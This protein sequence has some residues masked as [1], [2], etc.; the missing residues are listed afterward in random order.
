MSWALS[1][2]RQENEVLGLLPLDP[3][4][5]LLAK[6]ELEL[7][8]LGGEDV[9]RR[10]ADHVGHPQ[11]LQRA[12]R[13]R[14]E[15]EVGDLLGPG[16]VH[17]VVGPTGVP[18]EGVGPALPA[19]LVERRGV[20][21][22]LLA[23]GF[24][25]PEHRLPRPAEQ[26]VRP[27]L[28]EEAGLPALADARVPEVALE[29]LGPALH[30][31][32][33]LDGPEVLSISPVEVLVQV[34]ERDEHQEV[35]VTVV[36]DA[37]AVAHRRHVHPVVGRGGRTG[38]Q[39]QSECGGRGAW[40]P[41]MLAR[42]PDA[43]RG[44][45]LCRCMRTP[46]IDG[47]ETL[48]DGE[49]AA[50]RDRF[51]RRGLRPRGAGPRRVGGPGPAGHGVAAPGALDAAR[52]GRRRRP[53]GAA[54]LL[55]RHASRPP[56]SR[57]SLGEGLV[58]RL[59]E[60]GLLQERAA[61]LACPFRLIPLEGL[62]ILGDEPSAGADAVM[63]P[64]PTTLELLRN[65]PAR[66]DGAVL[67]LGTGA[68]TFALALAGR[69]ASRVVATD[70]NPRAASI[71]RFNARLNGLAARRPRRATSRP[72]CA[73]SAFAGSSPSRRTSSGRPRLRRWSSSTEARGGTS[74]PFVSWR[75]SP[76]CWRIRGTAL[77]LFDTPLEPSSPLPARVRGALADDGLELL[78]LAAPGASAGAQAVAYAALAHPDLGPDYARAVERN[79]AH[80]EA[81]GS[82]EW[83]HVL[84][85]VRRSPGGAPFTVQLPVTGLLT[86]GPAALEALLSGID[87][88][89]LPED[90]ATHCAAH[91]AAGAPAPR[92]AHPRGRGRAPRGAARRAET[93]P[94][95][96]PSAATTSPSSG[97]SPPRR[98]WAPR[99]RSSPG[100]LPGRRG[101]T[102]SASWPGGACWWTG[103]RCGG[104]PER[105]PRANLPPPAAA[106]GVR[107]P[108]SSVSPGDPEREVACRSSPS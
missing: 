50:L 19:L 105:P 68:G 79:R 27:V 7:A 2:E 77:V 101:W 41:A 38:E 81:L 99:W 59:V 11:R 32:E 48:T 17:V 53:D 89:T 70:L 65:L 1:V 75:P 94:Q 23:L 83:K 93:S 49:L 4:R 102:G 30:S 8:V 71:T 29:G 35:L 44:T 58:R 12:S 107:S 73:A 26:L 78:L 63:G 18:G 57:R 64:G 67:D 87:A 25:G 88:A 55:R 10:V 40:A 72:R 21:D 42:G 100:R 36:E 33:D 14:P 66:C 76:R 106:V 103:G 46:P 16:P 108:P 86:R 97:S 9:P 54:L 43:G 6:N 20:Q 80:L 37:K 98:T 34:P 3:A 28:E 90:G 69:G 82:R 31:P 85:C 52:A 56:S 60:A 22:C 47:L 39:G 91:A 61:G 13:P 74:S 51:R 24:G 92:R 96:V 45:L 5:L 62:W 84:A 104:C 15:T 95:P